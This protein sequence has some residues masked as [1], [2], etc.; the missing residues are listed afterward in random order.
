M[1]K[2]IAKTTKCSVDS[3]SDTASIQNYGLTS[4]EVVI[5]SGKFEEEFEI[6]ID[7]AIVFEYRI[8]RCGL[9]AFAEKRFLA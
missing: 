5:L 7:P 9:R 4:L 1:R 3:I 2:E 8:H 6:E